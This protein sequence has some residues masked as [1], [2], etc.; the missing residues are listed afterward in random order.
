VPALADAMSDRPA[1]A[2][3]L[4]GPT[5]FWAIAMMDLGIFL[6][7]TVA[8]CAGLLRGTTWAPKAMYAVVGWF[9]LVGPAVA[10]MAIAMYMNDDPNASAGV[11][12]F[13]TA[14]GLAFALLAV[15][16]YRPLFRR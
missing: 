9:G 3:Y 5:F 13:M 6:P 7:A 15:I 16:L 11:A 1:D 8:A 4:A 10:G 2:G 12:V 14:L